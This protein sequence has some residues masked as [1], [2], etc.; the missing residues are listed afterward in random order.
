MAAAAGGERWLRKVVL[1]RKK[2]FK[3]NGCSSTFC[4]CVQ[5]IPAAAVGGDSC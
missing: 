4:G 1:E 2:S 5:G 3:C